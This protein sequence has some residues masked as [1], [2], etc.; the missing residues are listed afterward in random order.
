ME[1]QR[2]IIDAAIQSQISINEDRIRKRYATYP[3]TPKLREQRLTDEDSNGGAT[4][5]TSISHILV[6]ERPAKPPIIASTK[7]IQVPKGKS[8]EYVRLLQPDVETI[9]T[10]E[11][12]DTNPFILTTYQVNDYVLRR[13][14]PSKIGGG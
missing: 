2:K 7:W 11:E 3:K 13:Y 5:P 9:D 6:N 4:K 14:P 8:Y 12:I 1:R 10:I